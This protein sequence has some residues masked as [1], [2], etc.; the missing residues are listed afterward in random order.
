M[1]LAGAV[2]RDGMQPHNDA[3]NDTHERRREVICGAQCCSEQVSKWFSPLLSVLTAGMR[4]SP[5]APLRSTGCQPDSAG[6]RASLLP[7]ATGKCAARASAG[8]SSKSLQEQ[9]ALVINP[10]Y[11]KPRHQA[12]LVTCACAARSTSLVRGQV[13]SRPTAACSGGNPRRVAF[14]GRGSQRHECEHCGE[15]EPPHVRAY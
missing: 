8:G 7:R 2:C 13:H 1:N 4:K 6:R 9:F 10:D 3:C 5:Q 11:D 15:V 12:S 14:A